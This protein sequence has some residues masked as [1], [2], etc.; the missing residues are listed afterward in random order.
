MIAVLLGDALA[1]HDDPPARLGLGK[2]EVDGLFFR[3]NLDPLDPLQ[4][5]NP[6]LDLLRLG[7]LVPE[8]V[9]EG[10]DLLDAL[11]LVLVCRD[12]LSPA[13]VLLL[14]VPREAAGIEV[15]ALVP[16]FGDL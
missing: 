14:F 1:L 11:L 4:F 5:F 2:A 10:F 12:Q 13:L 16:Q 7:R 8:A 3:W 15:Q 6:A 9:D